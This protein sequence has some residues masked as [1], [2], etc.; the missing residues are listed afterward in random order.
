L[1][2]VSK[3]SLFPQVF[4]GYVGLTRDIVNFQNLVSFPCNLNNI[5]TQ[6]QA[7]AELERQRTK[8]RQYQAVK[9]R[10]MEQGPEYAKAMR[11]KQLE[12]QRRCEATKKQ[13]LEQDPGYALQFRTRR[14]HA[15]KNQ[16]AVQAAASQRQ[17]N[18][19]DYIE[20][21]EALAEEVQLR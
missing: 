11:E 15:K 2:F 14:Q 13:R 17:S 5:H 7:V 3:N 8:R 21:R 19:A 4:K 20:E 1:F 12:K 10:R 6:V 18:D 16:R 9:K